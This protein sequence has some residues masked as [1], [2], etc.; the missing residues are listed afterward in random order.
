MHFACG[1]NLFS[2][3]SD[4]KRHDASVWLC[5]CSWLPCPPSPKKSNSFLPWISTSTHDCRQ[6]AQQTAQRAEEQLNQ[7]TIAYREIRGTHEGLPD[8]YEAAKQAAKEA[9]ESLAARDA[10]IQSLQGQLFAKQAELDALSGSTE[11]RTGQLLKALD[12]EQQRH[13]KEMSEAHRRW[14]ENLAKVQGDKV[15]AEACAEQIKAELQ[16]LQKRFNLMQA[17]VHTRDER[18]GSQIKQLEAGV[19][20]ASPSSWD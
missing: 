5:Y 13:E 1:S 4:P 6:I 8:R 2:P 10:T 11:S 9:S 15:M 7:V 16:D 14:E 3:H 20:T 17:E 12:A 19:I 18:A